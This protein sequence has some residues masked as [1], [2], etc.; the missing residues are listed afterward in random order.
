[1]VNHCFRKIRNC[2]SNP[3][4]LDEE[5]SFSGVYEEHVAIAL[6]SD[7]CERSVSPPVFS[8]SPNAGGPYPSGVPV[9]GHGVTGP[10]AGNVGNS[11]DSF[12][13]DVGQQILK[14]M[15]VEAGDKLYAI[16]AGK[17]VELINLLDLKVVKEVMEK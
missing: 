15:G 4:R 3:G 16:R 14:F 8:T 5:Q 9:V 6:E 12:A 7:S 13:M 11:L 1:M 2:F 17:K 10:P